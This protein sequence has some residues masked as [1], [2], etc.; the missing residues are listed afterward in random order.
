MTDWYH[1]ATHSKKFGSLRKPQKFL[2]N[3][4]FGQIPL[5]LGCY[6]LHMPSYVFPA[7][8]GPKWVK[9]VLPWVES[10]WHE[11][12]RYPR[13]EEL[14][15]KFG[16]T[17]V[18][19]LQMHNSKFYANC[20]RDRGIIRDPEA[21][22]SEKQVAA[23]SLITN[24]SDTRPTNVKMV[25]IGVTNEQL[26][27]WYQNPIFQRELASRADSI[28][29]NIFPE[30][31]AQ[32]ARQIKG[33]NFNALKFYYEIT[34]RAQSP[35]TVNVKLAMMKLIEIVQ[36]YVQDPEVLAKI[37]LEM[38]GTLPGQSVVSEAVAPKTM[39][40]LYNGNVYTE[41]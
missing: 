12:K 16:F 37:A 8:V 22:L 1:P 15:Q 41:L 40:E 36:K 2:K 29:D 14:V 7:T 25:S 18:Q 39:K 13:D 31:Q 38:R 26:N 34:G 5:A 20:L 32:L 9:K 11:K 17:D 30:A 6:P 35:E 4:N 10:F 33:G 23:I 21:D 19:L 3:F 24:F 28:L 27:G